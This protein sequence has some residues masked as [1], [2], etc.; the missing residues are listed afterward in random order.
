MNDDLWGTAMKVYRQQCWAAGFA[1]CMGLCSILNAQTQ[2]TVFGPRGIPIEG[3]ILNMTNKQIEVQTGSDTR[4][5]TVDQVR[6]INFADDPP[7]LKKARQFVTEGRMADVIQ[8]LNKINIAEIK[9][10]R[11]KLDI[12][13]YYALATSKMALRGVASLTDAA[14]QMIDFASAGQD[15][16]HYYE[17]VRMIGDLAYALGRYEAA[18]Q[19]YKELYEAPGTETKVEAR[20]RV[21]ECLLAEEKHEEALNAFDQVINAD[22]G[23]LDDAQGQKMI[24]KVGRAVCLAATGKDQEGISILEEIIRDGDARNTALFARAYNGLGECHLRAGRKKD[25]LLAYLHTDVLFHADSDAHA[26]ALYHLSKLWQ[27][28]RKADRALKAKQMLRD[29]YKGTLWAQKQ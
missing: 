29:R 21:A 12:Q 3:T 8:E 11:I 18:Q 7:E 23:N 14:R 1:A 17:A 5:F 4:T 25:A 27:D 20:I 28:E 22:L 9:Q 19:R 24:A 15:N 26:E 10:D 6:K 16:Y 13:F 2:D